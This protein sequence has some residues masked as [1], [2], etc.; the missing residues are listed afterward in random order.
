MSKPHY[1]K[2]A[3]RVYATELIRRTGVLGFQTFILKFCMYKL[4]SHTDIL[5]Q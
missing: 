3:M 1:C 4:H 5:S 2:N